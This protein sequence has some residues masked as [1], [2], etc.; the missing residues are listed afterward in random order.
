MRDGR[1][2][3]RASRDGLKG[4]MKR[5]RGFTLIEIL[6]SLAILGVGLTVILELFSGGL[7]SAKISEEYTRAMWYGKDKMEEMLATRDLSEGVTE[8][9]FDDRF[10]WTSKVK[11]AN[12]SLGQDEMA[13]VNLPIDLYQIIVKVTWSSGK[14][15]KSLEI[16]SLRAFKS[17]EE[18]GEKT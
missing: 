3:L 4:K 10:S 7:R 14:G 12:P 1:L 6:V 17:E 5:Q 18:T 2:R 16:E 13:E 15:Q 9:N 11:K 8:G